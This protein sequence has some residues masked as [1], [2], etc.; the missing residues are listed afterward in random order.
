MRKRFLTS[1]AMVVG[2]SIALSAAANSDYNLYS[3]YF[4]EDP[5]WKQSR[6]E[7]NYWSM[8]RKYNR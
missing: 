6:C 2:A 3:S 8:V 1:G 4:D 5:V 7:E